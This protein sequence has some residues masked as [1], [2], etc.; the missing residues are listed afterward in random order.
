[1]VPDSKLQ[2]EQARGRRALGS[3]PVALCSLPDGHKLQFE[4]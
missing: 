4:L 1:M 2:S 3:G